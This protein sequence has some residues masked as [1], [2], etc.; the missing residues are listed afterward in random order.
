[1]FTAFR[2]PRHSM[3]VL[4]DEDRK[5]I[6]DLLESSETNRQR[7]GAV[8]TG[9]P[10]SDGGLSWRRWNL[11]QRVGAV[12]GGL[13]AVTSLVVVAWQGIEATKS[14]KSAASAANASAN[15]VRASAWGAAT[16][17][18]LTF[19]QTSL[20][21]DGNGTLDPY[22]FK[23][24]LLTDHTPPK[25]KARFTSLASMELD[26]LD[27][28]RGFASLLGDFVDQQAVRGWE[29]MVFKNGPAVCEVYN[30][31]RATYGSALA[32]DSAQ[33]CPKGLPRLTNP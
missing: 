27:G 10:A 17:A 14:A 31:Y 13:I 11:W 1:M 26:L 20:Q 16:Q 9:I 21:A 5:L 4:S 18:L 33:F 7:L 19:D 12:L 8:P 24:V 25:V 2:Q 28:Y 15:A 3:L 30:Y 6:R 23:R 32:Q 22:F 29:Q